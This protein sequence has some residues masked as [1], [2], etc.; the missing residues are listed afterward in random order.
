MRVQYLNVLWDSVRGNHHG[1]HRHA[2]DFLTREPVWVRHKYSANQSRCGDLW[3]CVVNAVH[4]GRLMNLP[5]RK[6]CLLRP[7]A[8]GSKRHQGR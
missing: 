2:L 4:V 3:T 7:K 6:K 5:S 8:G 1:K